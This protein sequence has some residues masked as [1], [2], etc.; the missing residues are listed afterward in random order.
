MAKKLGVD[1]PK[2]S[3]TKD[4]LLPMVL[5]GVAALSAGTALPFVVPAIAG[6]LKPAEAVPIDAPPV[7][8]VSPVTPSGSEVEMTLPADINS[9][10]V[11]ALGE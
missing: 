8:P 1:F 4:T 11:R 7:E 9:D 2:P 6:L 10:F 3:W 5:A